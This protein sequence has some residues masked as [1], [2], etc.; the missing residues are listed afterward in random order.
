MK[1]RVLWA[2]LAVCSLALVQTSAWANLEITAG[3]SINA[4]ADFNAPLASAGA[5]VDLPTCGH[6]W[7]PRGVA[8][9]WQPYT[10]GQWEWTDAGWYWVSDEPWAWACYHYGNWVNDPS[11]GWCWIPGTQWAPAWVNWRTGGDYIG[12]APC[13]PGGAVLAADQF[14]F[15][16]T[17]NFGEPVRMDRLIVHNT[18]IINQ[19]TV[20]GSAR[21]ETVSI[22]GAQRSVFF[23]HGPDVN[24]I[25]RATGRRFTATPIADVARRTPAPENLRRSAPETRTP[26]RTVPPTGR[27]QPPRQT[28]RETP[29]HTAPLTPPERRGS[30]ASER[31]AA[32]PQAERPPGATGRD[33]QRPA[34]PPQR[35]HQATPATPPAH[36]ENRDKDKSN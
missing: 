20:I 9:G 17:R 22:D 12:W 21:R 19:T 30:S 35:P 13:G 32:P 36:E 1:M 27:E 3:V 29:E 34:V 15:M 4:V 31:P 2:G 16:N 14:V 18:T 6:C 10:V 11:Y 26:E 7:R 8:V 33:Q 28:P 25:Q 5:W 24:T 23:N